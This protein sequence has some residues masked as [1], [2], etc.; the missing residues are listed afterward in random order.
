MNV[1][2]FYFVRDDLESMNPGKMAAQVS[3]AA[4][5]LAERGLCSGNSTFYDLYKSWMNQTTDNFGVAHTRAADPH[6]IFDMGADLD[7][8]YESQLSAIIN[9][10]TLEGAVPN[11]IDVTVTDPEYPLKDGR[12]VHH[13]PMQTVRAVMFD[14]DKHPTLGAAFQKMSYRHP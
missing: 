8:D 3:H 4:A 1:H 5:M 9:N 12:T 11:I 2:Q 7:D 14:V 10:A 13:F 6:D